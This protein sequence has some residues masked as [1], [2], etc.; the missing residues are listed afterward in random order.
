MLRTLGQYCWLP[1]AVLGG[2]LI[3]LQLGGPTEINFTKTNL[4]ISFYQQ[5][6]AK[7]QEISLNLNEMDREKKKKHYVKNYSKI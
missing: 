3:T 1:Q 2:V 5:E 7:K 4:S 6:R